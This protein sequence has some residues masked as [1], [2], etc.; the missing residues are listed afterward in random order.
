VTQPE[1]RNLWLD[2]WSLDGRFLVLRT[3]DGKT[4]EVYAAPATGAVA[5]RLLRRMPSITDQYHVSPAGDRI[6]FGTKQSVRWEVT[7]ASFP[8]FT[9]PRQNT[10]PVSGA[11]RPKVRGTATRT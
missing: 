7:V 10:Q 11:A 5:P 8:D 3:G 1:A 2:D 6:A 9:W 4:S